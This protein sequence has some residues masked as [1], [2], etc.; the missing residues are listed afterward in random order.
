VLNG[1]RLLLVDD[2]QDVLTVLKEE[3]VDS[4]TGCVIDEA[5][6]YEDAVKL[7]ESREYDLAVLDIMGVRGFDLLELAVKKGVKVA[8]LTAHALSPEALKKSHDMGAHAYLPKDKLGEIIPFL[9]NVLT[10]EF[11]P[12][13]R[14]LLDTLGEFF[15][16]RLDIEQVTG[17]S[18][19]K[20]TDEWY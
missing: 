8:M 10:Y 1:K 5:T 3:I 19:K 7:M 18:W 15:T 4:C 11:K 13:W 2:E 20:W 9:E 6:T 12:G 14:H 16:R 17:K